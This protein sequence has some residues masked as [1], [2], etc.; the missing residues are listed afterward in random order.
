MQ[1]A[2]KIINRISKQTHDVE[3][4]ESLSP[5]SKKL[6][7]VKKSSQ[8]L[9]D[10]IRES[11]S[12]DKIKALPNSSKFSNSM[13]HMIGSLMS[14]RNSLQLTQNELGRANILG[15]PIKISSDSIKIKENI[16][17]LTPAIY[18]ALSNSLYTVNTMKNDDGFLMLYNI[19]KDLGY[20]G[21]KDRPSN[22]KNFFTK[23]LPKKVSEIHNIRFDK[24]TD[25]SDDLQGEGVKNYHTI[26]HFRYLYQ[27]RKITR[28][29]II[30]SY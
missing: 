2:L 7:E 14:S 18:R 17:N 5:V 15:V 30:W 12:N 6:D 13:K 29:K 28:S 26:Y 20:T 8:K 4:A 10:V 19:L 9:G 25:D 22:R 24:N 27:T 16:Y 1:L 3:L 11:N 23:D 21:N